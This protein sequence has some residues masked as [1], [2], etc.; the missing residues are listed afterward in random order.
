MVNEFKV[1]H[2]LFP[3]LT[4]DDML[5]ECENNFSITSMHELWWNMSSSSFK[6]L[7]AIF[8]QKCRKPVN[9]FKFVT[10]CDA[11]LNDFLSSSP[12][13]IEYLLMFEVD[14]VYGV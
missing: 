4:F 8:Y 14:L 3:T 10:A 1:L 7:F 11:M 2:P 9:P 12:V 13:D 5:V 6:E